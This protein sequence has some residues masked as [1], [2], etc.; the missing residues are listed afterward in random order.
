MDV[1]AGAGTGTGTGTGTDG[2]LLQLI[3]SE[4]K[5]Q[6]SAEMKLARADLLLDKMKGEAALLLAKTKDKN[7]SLSC[8]LKSQKDL[9]K[10]ELA[11]ETANTEA[12]TQLKKDSQTAKTALRKEHNKLT[13]KHDGVVRVGETHKSKISDHN[14]ALSNWMKT[15]SELEAEVKRLTKDLKAATKRVDLQVERKLDHEVSMQQLRN[16]SKQ[17]EL[18]LAREKF[19]D[20]KLQNTKKAPPPSEIKK[21]QGPLSLQER[22]DFVSHQAK[23]KKTAKEEEETRAKLKKDNKTRDVR[24][25]LGFAASLM[26]NRTNGR[27]WN[28]MM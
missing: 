10:K 6:V 20:K 15:K 9:A 2:K 27:M 1:S 18:D 13:T 5:L 3:E 11:A 4:R 26:K 23:V 7:S 12:Q 24:S 16:Q 25:N 28:T 17:L 19:S 8:Q 22:K 21:K 14:L